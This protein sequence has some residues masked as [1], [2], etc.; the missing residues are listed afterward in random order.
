M[1]PQATY[2]S[3]DVDLFSDE[4]LAD[5]YPLYK[6]LREAGVTVYL[7]K[8]DAWA[9]PRYAEVRA[10]AADWATFSS[11]GIGLTPE[12]NAAAAPTVLASD[13]PV[14]EE[15][16]RTLD[17][18]LSPHLLR[19][20]A[21]ASIEQR[22]E[23]IVGAA[24]A[25][26]RFDA[27]AD[28]AQAF[29]TSVVADLIG[30]PQE[31]R[32]RLLYFADG[33]F[34]AFGP[35]NERTLAGLASMREQVEYLS[36]V[37]TPD[38]LLPGSMGMKIYEAADRGEIPHESCV[39]LMMSYVSAVLDTTIH[40]IS[41]AIWLFARHPEQWDLVRE[42]PDRV[43][44]MAFNEVLRIESPIPFFGRR[45]TRDHELGGVTLPEGSQVVLMFGSANRD[46]RKYREPERFDVGRNS[47]D[48]LAFG[49]GAHR[50]AGQG[51]ARMQFAAVMKHLA[52]GVRRFEIEG[53]PERHLNND[54]RGLSRLPVGVEKSL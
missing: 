28:V 20:H 2:P 44:P 22:A 3:S 48:H 29:P 1:N 24:L 9:L 42:D 15:R 13:P 27:V 30:L 26:G 54:L 41:S 51:L 39:P 52:R 16:R 14:H 38:R 7:E 4:A 6:R 46:E 19:R 47:A 11:A 45:V 17:Y 43:I 8:I 37:A 40:A 35:A 10:A 5:P 34:N 36:T 21:Q 31:G 53:E 49:N 23:E 32:D 25:R 33:T 50:C 12:M 18:G